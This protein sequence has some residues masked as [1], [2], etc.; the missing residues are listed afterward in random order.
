MKRTLLL[1]A[2]LVGLV[3]SNVMAL[4]LD[5]AR[6]QGRVGET[7]NGYLGALKTDA[8]TQA[9]VNDINAARKANYQQLAKKNNISVDDIARLAGQKLVSRAKSGEYVQ[10]INGKW[11]Q[12]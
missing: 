2:F 6:T 12:K 7:L 1:C 11:L 5:E 3:S 9:L 4:T 10:G 8:E